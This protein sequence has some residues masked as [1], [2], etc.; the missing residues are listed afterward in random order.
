MSIRAAEVLM[1]RPWIESIEISI[2]I[3]S[4]LDL[5]I[6]SNLDWINCLHCS[7]CL[8]IYTLT[9]AQI[10]C[11]MTSFRTCI[12]EVLAAAILLSTILEAM[13]NVS[14]TPGFSRRLWNLLL[15]L[16]VG[17][18]VARCCIQFARCFAQLP[19][20]ETPHERFRNRSVDHRLLYPFRSGWA[21]QVVCTCD[22]TQLRLSMTSWLKKLTLYMQRR[23]TLVCVFLLVG[24]LLCHCVTL[25]LRDKQSHS[26]L[27]GLE[28]S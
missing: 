22:A 16:A 4:N 27:M 1:L 17:D 14:D 18:S 5:E 2:W 20:Y 19:I 21:H 25:H 13:V 7:E 6:K 23:L 15:K 28:I 12:F 9:G 11:H 8:F 26:H 10:S 24:K 3:D